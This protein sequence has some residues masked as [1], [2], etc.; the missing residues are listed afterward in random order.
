VVAP[1]EMDMITNVSI[2][3][4]HLIVISVADAESSLFCDPILPQSLLLFFLELL[5]K[6]IVTKWL[7][8]S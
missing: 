2:V 6:E 1:V 5:T 7:M 3:T 4:R 8:L